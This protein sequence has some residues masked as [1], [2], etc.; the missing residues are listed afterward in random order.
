MI[1][2]VAS[3]TADISFTSRTQRRVGTIHGLVSFVFNTVV[4][5]LT[6]NLMAGLF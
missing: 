2:G 5:A 3:Q 6:I 1:I 4:L